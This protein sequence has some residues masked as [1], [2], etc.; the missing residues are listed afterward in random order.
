M[1]RGLFSGERC[2][3]L[4][5]TVPVGAYGPVFFGIPGKNLKRSEKLLTNH[6][7]FDMLTKRATEYIERS[8]RKCDETGDCRDSW[9]LPRSMS[10]TGK[11]GMQSGG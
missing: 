7:V 4:P 9:S 3:F 1:K 6:P 8:V 5:K 11:A 2:P 10:G